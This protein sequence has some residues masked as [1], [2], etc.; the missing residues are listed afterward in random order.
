MTLSSTSIAPLAERDTWQALWRGF[1]MRC[2]SCGTG[3][4]FRAFL[5]VSDTCPHC[6]EA[7]HHHKADDAPA[8]FTILIVGHI[9]IP[10]LLAVEVA[11]KPDMLLHMIVWPTLTVVLSLLLLPRIK[12]AL[13][14]LQW[15]NRM[16][17]FNPDAPDEDELAN[18]TSAG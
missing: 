3:N 10:L 18:G 17:G 5:K 9:V 15:A 13:V 12:G 14:A 11:Y 16:H 2:P 1:L 8:Y 6:D 7:L 4:I